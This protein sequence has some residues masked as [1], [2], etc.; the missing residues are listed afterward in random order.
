MQHWFVYYKVPPAMLSNTISEVRR[1]QDVLAHAS[2]VRGRLLARNGAD[3]AT[4]MEIYE[5]IDAP[6]RFAAM[7]DQAVADAN[8][9]DALRTARRTER[10]EDV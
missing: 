6:E 3:A 8:V 2:G 7:L 10:F 4:L 5:R 9:P 1:M